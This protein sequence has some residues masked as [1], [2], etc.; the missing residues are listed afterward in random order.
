MKLFKS[1]DMLTPRTRASLN[2]KSKTQSENQSGYT[3]KVH[4]VQ[5]IFS[6]TEQDARDLLVG[7]PAKNLEPG[8]DFI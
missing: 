6:F 3:D 4:S 7:F 8:Q 2:Y 1:K 5:S